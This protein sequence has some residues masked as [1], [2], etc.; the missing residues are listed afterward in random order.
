M[1]IKAQ[2]STAALPDRP[3]RYWDSIRL[4]VFHTRQLGLW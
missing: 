3:E 4:E 2:R 1:Y